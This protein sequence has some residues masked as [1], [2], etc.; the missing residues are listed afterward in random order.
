MLVV[1][2]ALGHRAP[3]VEELSIELVG[4]V[5]ESEDVP[6][7]RAKAKLAPSETSRGS[8]TTRTRSIPVTS[9]DSWALGRPHR[10]VIDLRPEVIDIPLGSR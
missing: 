10:R 2:E 5:P 8:S 6:A 9:P 1:H 4:S 7:P 3:L